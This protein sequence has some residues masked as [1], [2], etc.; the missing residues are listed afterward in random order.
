MAQPY[1]VL[2]RKYRPISF[3]DVV[4]QPQVTDTLRNEIKEGRIS[5]SY[6]FTGS[7]GTGKTTCAKIFA[8]AVNCLNPIDGNPCCECEICR[9][10]DDGSVLDVVELD[11]ASNNGVEKVRQIIEEADFLPQKAKM[12]VYI[13]D[14]VHMFSQ[15]AFNALLKTIEEP[16]E[17][18]LFI[19]ATTEVNKLLPTIL[20]RCQRF[21]F[22]R[23]SSETIAARLESVCSMEGIR[24]EHEAAL[25]IARLADGGMRDALSI[26]D[27]CAGRSPD[28]TAAVVNDTSG[29][30]G[31]EYLFKLADAITACDSSLALETVDA[32]YQDS[33]DMSKLCEEMADHFRRLMLIKTMKDPGSVLDI[34]SQE[35]AELNTQAMKMN[36]AAVLHS[37]DSFRTALDRM[38]LANPR[39]ELE[40]T[41]VRLCSPELD[42]SKDALIRRIAALE[43]GMVRK[44]AQEEPEK[45]AE[46]ASVS[47]NLQ[48]ERPNAGSAADVSHASAEPEKPAARS[49]S[50]SEDALYENA[51]FL[52]SWPEIVEK[53]FNARP[54][55]GASFSS[56]K[57][58][59]S[60]VNGK[61]YLLIED[62]RKL[63]FANLRDTDNKNAVREIVRQVTG[64]SYIL[65]PYKRS[66]KQAEE[67]EDPVSSLENRMKDAGIPVNYIDN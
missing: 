24:I 48:K 21:D 17:H 32:L 62:A 31:R 7:R 20:S 36:L 26:L 50:V 46:P 38:R 53:L 11:A 3:N 54:S 61:N 33:K 59:T 14:E 16:P 49:A 44:P 65:G 30:A 9:G 66:S 51:V 28:I 41:L 55:I 60:T 5:H 1:K 63:A 39:V 27:Q 18:V 8:K 57:A 13:L 29:T 58:Y 40:M 67:K 23:I 19:L 35:L 56:T 12:R 47:E 15:G 22:K 10:I 52:A 2:Y 6:L 34:S 45:S 25:L 37:L 43:S 42:D 4:G 64:K